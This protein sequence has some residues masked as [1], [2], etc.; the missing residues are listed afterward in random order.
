MQL[1]S[2]G[3]ERRVPFLCKRQELLLAVGPRFGGTPNENVWLQNSPRRGGP[4]LASSSWVR[5]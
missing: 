4:H 3:N 5:A 2:C 1:G